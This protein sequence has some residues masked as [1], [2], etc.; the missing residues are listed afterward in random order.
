[1]LINSINKTYSKIDWM[2]NIS[3]DWIL[4]GSSR[5]AFEGIL[6]WTAV[7]WV[8]WSNVYKN[9]WKMNEWET[10]IWSEER[11]IEGRSVLKKGLLSYHEEKRYWLRKRRK[12]GT[13]KD[14]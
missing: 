6:V 10:W 13:S 2:V 1:M 8:N 11:R 3:H 9:E 14:W 5:I 12:E 4:E 7:P